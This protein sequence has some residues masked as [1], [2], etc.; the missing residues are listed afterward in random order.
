MYPPFSLVANNAK[1]D[2][3]G[4]ERGL[5]REGFVRNL[6]QSVARVVKLS[7]R[8]RAYEKVLVLLRLEKK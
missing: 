7:T 4:R 3:W 6:A 5:W 1:Y 2:T 8:V